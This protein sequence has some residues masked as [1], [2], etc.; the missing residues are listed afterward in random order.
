MKIVVYHKNTPTNRFVESFEAGLKTHGYN[1]I[2]KSYTDYEESDLAVMWAYKNRHIIEGQKRIGKNILVLER[3][4]IGNRFEYSSAGLNGLNG[5]A[6]FPNQ[7]D[8]ARYDSIFKKECELKDWQYNTSGDILL[9]GQVSTD[10]AV[11]HV[12]IF[13][14]Y[15]NMIQKIKTI[16]PE[17]NVVFRPHPE[18]KNRWY[19]SGVII[20]QDTPLEES[21]QNKFLTVTFSSN[22]GVISAVNGIPVYAEDVG[23]MAKSVATKDLS[24]I[25]YPDRS[26]WI[27][28]LAYSQWNCEEYG[29]GLAWDYINPMVS[30]AHLKAE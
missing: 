15:G 29:S 19:P 9:I 18:E 22:S 25:L 12:N 7:S 16:Y 30:Q 23:S 11:R 20:E 4:Y 21:L 8:S 2:R 10:A 1:P 13:E 27:N 24:K 5:R 6:I 14:W 3:G 26:L 28:N 17:K